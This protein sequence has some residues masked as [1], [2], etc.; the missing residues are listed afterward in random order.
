MNMQERMAA[1]SKRLTAIKAAAAAAPAA[2]VGKP[3]PAKP[4]IRVY[5]GG[6]VTRAMIR[7]A[8]GIKSVTEK[9]AESKA[10]QHGVGSKCPHCNGTGRYL[11]HTNPQRNERCY[12]CNGKGVLDAR[13]MAFLNR[14][15]QGGG[16]VCWVVSAPAA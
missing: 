14:R 8:L 4:V 2:P 7:K 11:F 6:V 12:R 16:P 5:M 13:D 1:A 3:K 10:S 9:W 15:L